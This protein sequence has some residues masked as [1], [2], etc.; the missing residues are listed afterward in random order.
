MRR[1]EQF[2]ATGRIA[3]TIA[4]E[5]RNPLTNIDLAA[6]QIRTELN[7]A[8]ESTNMLFEMINRNSKR[9][10]Q[11]ITELLNA[12]RFVDLTY[13]TVSINTL[14]DE[15]LELA[16]DRIELDHVVINKKYNK[17]MHDIS[18][19]PVKI[20]IAFLNIIINAIEA[21]QAG[22]KVLK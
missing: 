3:R 20:K 18:V 2:A 10:N 11:L 19:D 14:M 13:E 9:I 1:T 4:H 15:V 6:G 16:G 17:D 21:M 5:V 7:N 22:Q 8:D 12:T